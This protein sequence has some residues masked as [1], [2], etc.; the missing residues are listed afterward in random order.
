MMR[1]ETL[2]SS[3]IHASQINSPW[4]LTNY[5]DW[6][7]L[8]TNAPIKILSKDKII[9]HRGDPLQFVYFIKQGRIK[10]SIFDENGQEKTILIYSVGSIFGEDSAVENSPYEVTTTANTDCTLA[11]M[12]YKEFLEKVV[13]CS[14]LSMQLSRSLTGKVMRLTHQIKEIALL[15][16]DERVIAYLIKLADSFGEKSDQ[17]IKISIS[18]THQEMADLIATSR[19]SVAK[20]MSIL[21]K[22]GILERIDGY[23]YIKNKEALLSWYDNRKGF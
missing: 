13:G 21:N 18:F 2:L 22:E 8:F 7:S 11:Y 9:F 10:S 14:S 16:S 5:E 20:I 17:G 12:P 1:N 19:V 3:K 4:Y 15:T 6:Y 23:I